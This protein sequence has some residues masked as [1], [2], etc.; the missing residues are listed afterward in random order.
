[1]TRIQLIK[2]KEHQKEFSE[3]EEGDVMKNNRIDE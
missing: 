3:V 2:G 1:M